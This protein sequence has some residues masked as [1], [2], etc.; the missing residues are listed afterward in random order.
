MLRRYCCAVIVVVADREPRVTGGRLPP[1]VEANLVSVNV[2]D[3][4]AE[5][6]VLSVSDVVVDSNDRR[7]ALDGLSLDLF[8][9]EIVGVAGVEG[10]G[11]EE[12]TALMSSLAKA[13]EGTVRVD[14][15]MVETGVAG[16]MARAGIAVVPADRHDSGVVLDLSVAENLFLVEP[17]QVSRHGFWDKE[18]SDRRARELISEFE[19][20]TSGPDAPLWSISGGNQQRIVL[21]RELSNSPKVLIASQPTR[22]LDVGAIE[23][24]SGRLRQA[25]VDGVGV[26]LISNELEEILDLADRIIVLFRGKVV[27]EMP[28]AEIDLDRLGMLM[29]GVTEELAGSSG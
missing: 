16:S 20:Q 3:A 27:G 6:P 8:P 19:I 28:R 13:R 11:Q 26:L 7:R 25:K 10:N 17:T 23:Y 4:D 29:G 9:G 5:Q 21:A 18:L 24:I 15:Q 2:G 12:L 22:G 14:G 1:A